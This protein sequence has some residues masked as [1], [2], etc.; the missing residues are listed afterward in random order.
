[1]DTPAPGSSGLLGSLRGFA[2]GLI[3]SVHDRIELVSLELH[4]EK[5]R[6]IQLLLWI[7]VIV[8]MGLLAIVFASFALVLWLWDT[9]R[10]AAVSGLAMAYVVALVAAILLFKRFLARMPKPFSATL[11][12]LQQ[13]RA[14]I[15]P[16][17]SQD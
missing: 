7:A 10:L 8:L 12:E 17:T 14:C 3:G 11:H 6:L 15:H 2:D 16:E 9:A 1:M 4:E 5:H 13:D